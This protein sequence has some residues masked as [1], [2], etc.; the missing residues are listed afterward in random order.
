MK[1]M[2]GCIYVE[3]RKTVVV[4]I[5]KSYAKLAYKRGVFTCPVGILKEGLKTQGVDWDKDVE[6]I[7]FVSMDTFQSLVSHHKVAFGQI[8][9]DL[10]KEFKDFM[11]QKYG[12]QKDSPEEKK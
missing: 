11:G 1:V 10:M 9:G 3:D 8:S 2:M 12:S 5:E 6:E 4:G 7:D